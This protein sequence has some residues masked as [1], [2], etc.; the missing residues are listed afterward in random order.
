MHLSYVLQVIQGSKHER[1]T[2]TVEE[3]LRKEKSMAFLEFFTRNSETEPTAKSKS[4][5]SWENWKNGTLI[6]AT[7]KELREF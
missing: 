5:K 3:I 2:E 7:V 4:L 6:R 1:E